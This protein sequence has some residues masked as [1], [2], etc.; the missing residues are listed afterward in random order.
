MQYQISSGDIM[1]LDGV[2]AEYSQDKKIIHTWS[3]PGRDGYSYELTEHYWKN[4]CPLCGKEGTLLFNPKKTAEGELTCSACDAD[5]DCVNGEDKWTP[6]RGTLTPASNENPVSADGSSSSSSSSSE[7][8]Y[9][10]ILSGEKT[11]KD[12]IGEICNGIDVQFL[13]KRNMIV[14]TDVETLYAEAAYLREKQKNSAEDIA[15]WQLQ[16]GTYDLDVNEY[17]FFNTVYVQ[18]RN[19]VVKE[20]FPDLVRV[21]GEVPKTYKEKKLS[22]TQAQKKAKMY[23]AAHMRDFGMGIKA[24]ILHDGGIDIGD[25]VTLENPLTLKNEIKKQE[26]ELPEFYFVKGLNIEWDEGP[27]TCD[28]ELSYSP[29][30]PERDESGTSLNSNSSSSGSGSN[31]SSGS[32]DDSG[33]TGD[34]EDVPTTETTEDT[35]DSKVWTE[36]SKVIQNAYPRNRT[37]EKARIVGMLVKTPCAYRNIALIVNTLGPITHYKN[38]NAVINAI[39]KAKGCL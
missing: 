7:A 3:Y 21:Y 20:S 34:T 5:Y 13:C 14:V 8:A 18:Y 10:P 16:D 24:S 1:A 26:D 39:R 27:I 31:G 12:L 33:I 15:L 38:Q 2:K 29:E 23:L 30:A 25:I 28:L 22:K 17:G 37:T 32:S 6:S 19:G 4:S 9:N 35:G 36:I 11:F